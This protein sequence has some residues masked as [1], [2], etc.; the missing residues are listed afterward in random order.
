M[1]RVFTWTNLGIA[2]AVL[3]AVALGCL[4]IGY[5]GAASA[6]FIVTI[7]EALFGAV[8]VTVKRRA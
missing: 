5:D 7:A 8:Y 4:A 6:V 3:L 2:V 1:T